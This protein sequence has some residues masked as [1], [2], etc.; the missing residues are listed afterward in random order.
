MKKHLHFPEEYDIILKSGR[1][2]ARVGVDDDEGPPVPIPNTEVKLIGA[3]NTWLVTAWENRKMPTYK[4]PFKGGFL[5]FVSK[6]FEQLEFGN[7]L[8]TNA[9]LTPICSSFI[10]TF[11]I[12]QLTRPYG[13][14]ACLLFLVDGRLSACQNH[15]LLFV[16]CMV[17][18]T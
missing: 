10:F 5:F 12:A 18:A 9:V 1:S 6:F 3:E 15:I 4:P 14:T 7:G 8:T 11:F 16:S 2:P 13:W 17:P